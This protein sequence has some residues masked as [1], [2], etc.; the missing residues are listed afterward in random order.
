MR[1]I[2]HCR[3][4]PTRLIYDGRG[5]INNHF[6][7]TWYVLSSILQWNRTVS[8]HNSSWETSPTCPKS[9][10]S[11]SRSWSTPRR[12]KRTHCQPKKVSFTYLCVRLHGLISLRSC[13]LLT[14]YSS[15]WHPVWACR[16]CSRLNAQGAAINGFGQQMCFLRCTGYVP[17]HYGRTCVK[18]LAE[19]S[20]WRL[21]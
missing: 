9:L 20:S 2:V 13:T 18:G 8:I 17:V 15:T 6:V 10:R 5:L 14:T 21:S 11:T 7:F 3:L 12:R 16:L 19:Q 1:L 4:K